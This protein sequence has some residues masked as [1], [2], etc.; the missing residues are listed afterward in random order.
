MSRTASFNP[1]GFLRFLRSQ[2]RFSCTVYPSP[3]TGLR[4][5]AQGVT[6]ADAE[7]PSLL[8]YDKSGTVRAAGAE[9]LAQDIVETALMEGWTK[10]EWYVAN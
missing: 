5:P 9:V 2:G 1:I 3:L 8:Y 10:A 4:F 6:C 7:V